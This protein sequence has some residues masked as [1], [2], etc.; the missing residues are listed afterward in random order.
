M[1]DFNPLFVLISLI[2]EGLAAAFG[3][4]LIFKE[5]W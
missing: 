5:K 1:N 4:S 3:L 2:L